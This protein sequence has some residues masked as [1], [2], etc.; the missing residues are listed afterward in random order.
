MPAYSFKINM[1]LGNGTQLSYYNSTFANSSGSVYIE[2]P[3]IV[4][5]I[6]NMPLATE[7]IES[8]EGVTVGT[9]KF[10]NSGGGSTYLSASFTGPADPGDSESGSVVFTDTETT[11][12]GG[13]K[14]YTFWGTKVCSVLGLPEGIPIYPENFKL[15]DD[16][17]DPNNYKSG[18]II[19]NGVSVK[20]SFKLT[21]QAR[22]KGNLVWDQ[23]FGEGYA[24]WV[25]GSSSDLRIGYEPDK[26][27]YEIVAGTVQMNVKELMS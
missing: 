4:T 14:K 25:S 2:A 1:E 17:D 16:E 15:S 13:L 3:Q 23:V 6:N 9:D 26:N 24:Q 18:D 10:S 12:R 8:E 11:T 27:V 22:V 19:A 7:Y 5:W 20:E 21:N